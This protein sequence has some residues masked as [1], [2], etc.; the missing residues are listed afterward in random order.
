MAVRAIATEPKCKLCKNPKRS[1]I[2]G[3]LELRSNAGKLEDGRR[4]TFTVIQPIIEALGVENLTLDNVKNHWKKH[5]STVGA[6]TAISM[7][8]AA[9]TAIALLDS[10]GEMADVDVSLRRMFT[11]GMAELEA[12]VANGEKSGIGVDLLVK[13]SDA[14]TRRKTQDAAA[15]LIVGLGTALVGAISGGKVKPIEAGDDQSS[16]DV[17]EDAE[18]AELDREAFA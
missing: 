18:Y 11:I 12:K 4:A 13:L 16:P 14:I 6:D 5:C 17:I 8:E 9:S 1:E 15:S 10:G 7:N 3:L 2:D